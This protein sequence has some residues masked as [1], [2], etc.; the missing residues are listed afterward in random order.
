[1]RITHMVDIGTFHQHHLF[2]HHIARDGMSDRRIRFMT[3]HAFQLDSLTIY[4]IV[5]SRQPEFIFFSRCILDLD[6][7]EPDD[8]RGCLHHF[9]FS[10][11]QLSN[12]RIAIWELCRPF[13][14]SFYIQ[15][16]FRGL[17]LSGIYHIH[18]CRNKH[19][20]HFDVFI[21]IQ[22][23][24]IQRIFQFIS[25]R[26]L[27][28]QVAYIGRDC[29]RTIRI[30]HIQIRNR[31]QIAHIHFRNRIQSDRPEDTRQAEHIL[32]FQKRTVGTA[33]YFSGHHIRPF[34]EVRSDVEIS[35]IA[36]VFG[37]TDILTVDP[38]IE[39]RID[40]IETDKNFASVPILRYLEIT[41]ERTDF[42]P[43][44]VSR[45]V[46]WRSTHHTSAPVIDRHF[47]L[48]DYRLVHIDRN[49]IFQA[50]V[51]LDS[52]NIPTGRNRDIIPAGYIKLR[53]IEVFRP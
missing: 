37:K 20:F 39:E 6:L 47:M 25:L 19:I 36:G 10:I 4:I 21:R 31:H 34:T 38:E 23:I 35:R 51:F 44:L 12:Q 28:I 1:M 5:T 9:P 3:V 32:R 50:T 14:G 42:I 24:G 16:S 11:L 52:I 49:S 43:V 33:I 7:T 8:R 18:R 2:F 27:F 29:Q 17:Y 15:D 46:C 41:T 22:L 30:S 40:S 26:N 48:E 53:L 13:P 45:P